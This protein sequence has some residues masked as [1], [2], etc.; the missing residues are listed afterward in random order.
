MYGL[1]GRVSK[2]PLDQVRMAGKRYKMDFS[3]P[4]CMLEFS[5]AQLSIKTLWSTYR[6]LKSLPSLSFQIPVYTL[7]DAVDT[8]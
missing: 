5:S 8:P 1:L 3:S 6:L 2:D 7:Q 4:F